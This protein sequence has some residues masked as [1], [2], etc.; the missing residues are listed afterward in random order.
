MT[1]RNVRIIAYK[2]IRD[3]LRN[4][5]FLLY[6]TAFAILAVAL[7]LLSLVG[8]GM[9]GHA[10]FGRTTAG[11]VN[12][13]LLIVPLMGLTIG[14]GALAAEREKGTLNYLLAQP[15]S[16]VEVLLGKYIGLATALAAALAVG[17]GLAAAVMAGKGVNTQIDSYLRL[18]GLS[19]VL[20]LAMLSVGVLI[21]SFASK[22]SVA[23]GTAIFLWLVLV[24]LSDLG[25]MGGTV[26]FKLKVVELFRLSLLNPLQ[27]YKMSMLSGLHATLDVLGP[28]GAY[29]MRTYGA[30]LMWMFYGLLAAW[31]VLP[32]AGAYLNFLR[33][34]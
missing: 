21:S 29:A 14:A 3:S 12:L 25:L 23:A 19:C 20:A 34:E 17:F 9:F 22:G 6:A 11:L 2:E 1:A 31:V 24:F 33:R 7:S 5:W 10:G 8:T 16:P 13:V 28:V 27:V 15:V 32:V 4:R 18:V 26:V 30:G